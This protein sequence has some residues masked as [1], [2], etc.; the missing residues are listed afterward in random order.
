M[1]VGNPAFLHAVIFEC[2]P[3]VLTEDAQR[4]TCPGLIVLMGQMMLSFKFKLESFP[5]PHSWW[6]TMSSSAF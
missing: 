2:P 6:Q 4:A 3:R 5:G 1:Y